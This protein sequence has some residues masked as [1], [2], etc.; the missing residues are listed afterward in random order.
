[1]RYCAS[2]L[3]ELEAPVL[4]IPGNHDVGQAGDAFQP[5]NAERIA[6][7]HFSPE[8]LERTIGVIRGLAECTR[9][10][11]RGQQFPRDLG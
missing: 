6:R 5:V 11:P 1:M 7:W 2:V 8:E 10:I 4:C 3:P 9:G